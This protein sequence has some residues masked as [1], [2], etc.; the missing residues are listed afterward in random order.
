LTKPG[1]VYGN[2]LSLIA[3]FL[4]ASSLD[5]S[6][7]F[8]LLLYAL[9]GTLLVI[10]CGCVINNV[11]DRKIDAKM[12]RTAQRSL[13]TGQIQP[14]QALLYAGLL[15]G[16]G[17]YLLFAYVNI[18][19]AIVGF[20]GLFFYLVVYGFAKRRT[21][22]STLLGSVSGATPL[23]AGYTAVTNQLDRAAL[24]LFLIMVCWQMPH[25]YAIAIYRLNEYKSAGL[26]VLPL[27]KGIK[28]TKL[29]IFVY[30]ALFTLAVLALTPLGYT[31]RLY[32]II[33]GLTAI[34]WL[35]QA[36]QGFSAKDDTKWARGFFISSL[37]VLLIICLALSVGVLLP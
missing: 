6:F 13:V 32:A 10:A 11:I 37:K 33:A 9:A 15:G 24:V 1:I 26:P 3:G 23:V 2:A 25:F 36:I 21:H 27:V 14:I 28:R 5:S 12:K 19:T 16:L 4:L 35:N 17:F 30:A 29:E 18:L 8:Q 22:W 20:V 34:W 31:G 7:S